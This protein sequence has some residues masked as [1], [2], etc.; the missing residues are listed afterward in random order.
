M[1]V[2]AST[3][4][5]LAQTTVPKVGVNTRTPTEP[6]HV[7]GTLRVEQLPTQGQPNATF[8]KP[9]GSASATKDQSYTSRY[10]VTA[11]EQGVLG[12]ASG[13]Q[14][15]FFYMPPMVV[16]TDPSVVA[17]P[18][19]SYDA[20]TQTYSIDL[21]AEYAAQFGRTNTVNAVSST[22]A[23]LPVLTAT[24]LNFIVTYYDDT[25][26][27]DVALSPAGVLTYK[28]RPG[29]VLT[30]RSFFNILFTVK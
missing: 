23:T 22:S 29:F 12:R 10:V 13:A 17:A 4:V 9:D 18:I 26:F 28:I 14:P 1:F 11:S 8:T 20:G 30:E 27:S 16:P 6:L 19:T 25:V 3:A 21:H 7:A 2:A 15:N 24:N 5:A